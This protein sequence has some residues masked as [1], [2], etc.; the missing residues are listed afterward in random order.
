MK[1]IEHILPKEKTYSMIH[2]RKKTRGGNGKGWESILKKII[3]FNAP[4]LQPI[5]E[6][7]K[8]FCLEGREVKN[9]PFPSF[10]NS[11]SM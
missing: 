5:L 3:K 2:K 11:Q 6:G 9:L 8:F 7:T 4:P 10:V 1:N